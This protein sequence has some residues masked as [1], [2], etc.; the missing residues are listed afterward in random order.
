MPLYWYWIKVGEDEWRKVT[1]KEYDA[2][3]GEKEIAPD[4]LAGF[5]F[6]GFRDG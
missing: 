4:A 2:W 1:K 5:F 6:G 3:E